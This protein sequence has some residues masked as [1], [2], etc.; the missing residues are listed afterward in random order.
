[1]LNGR[2]YGLD[3]LIAIIIRKL[4]EGAEAQF[5]NIGST[6][7]VGRPVIFSGAKTAADEAF[8]LDRLKSAV[9][10]AGFKH[11]SFELEPVAAAYGYDRQLTQD[12]LVLIGDFG[13][14]TSDFSVVKLGPKARMAKDRKFILGNQGVPIAGDTFDS[15]IVRHLVAPT[16]GSESSYRS[17]GKDLPVPIWLYHR[18]ASWHLVSFLK[19]RQTMEML[20]QIKTQAEEPQKIEALIH[21]ISH[22]L[23]YSLYRAVEHA[24]IE[25]SDRESTRFVFFESPID[26]EANLTRNEFE[27]WIAED[28]KMI[29]DCVD[30]L[31]KS[32]NLQPVHIDSVFLTGGSAFVP[33]VRRI[34]IERFGEQN[35]KGGEELTTVAR[36]LALSAAA[37][38][39]Y[40]F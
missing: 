1:M 37:N 27:S 11:V 25:L 8:A 31:L 36:G 22:D 6:V 5:G 14:G 4:R 26:I 18:L 16:L 13:G 9:L 34:F 15:R 38:S 28:I 19:T 40:K 10:K 21:I 7:V 12:Q 3:D 32:C 39:E 23:G 33:A 17:M 2:N 30:G 20:R 35:I 29:E 24:K